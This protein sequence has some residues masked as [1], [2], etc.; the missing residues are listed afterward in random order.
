MANRLESHVLAIQETSRRIYRAV[1][2]ATDGDD[3]TE[4]R[5]LHIGL[6][7]TMCRTYRVSWG[8]CTSLRENVP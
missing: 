1:L 4:Y 2:I 3:V 5:P 6:T 8:E 7:S